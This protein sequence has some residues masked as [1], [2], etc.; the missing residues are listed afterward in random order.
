MFFTSIEDVISRLKFVFSA[1]TDTELADSMGIAKTTLSSWKQRGS[2]PYAECVSVAKAREISLDWLLL[3]RGRV[4]PIHS[5]EISDS[6]VESEREHIKNISNNLLKTKSYEESEQKNI[7]S[8][9]VVE[10]ELRI[11]TSLNRGDPSPPERVPAQ[12]LDTESLKLAVEIVEEGLLQ[13]RRAMAPDK[14]AELILAV[15]DLFTDTSEAKTD[16]TKS[17]LRLI[18]S[19]S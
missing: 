10:S 14:K 12:L 11:G 1:K 17:V 8:D 15:Y 18:K 13:R 4:V 19:V 7:S 3:G 6:L 16:R 2:I 9:S 5:I